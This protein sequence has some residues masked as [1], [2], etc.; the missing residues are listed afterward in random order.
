M[1]PPRPCYDGSSTMPQHPFYSSAVWRKARETHLRRHPYCE[2]CQNLGMRVRGSEVDHRIAI[3][4]GGHPTDPG[5]LRTMCKTHHS[6]KTIMLDG[7][8]KDCGKSL[9]TTGPDG[10]PVEIERPYHAPRKTTDPRRR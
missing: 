8:H 2:V 4:A 7:Q 10:W 5:N 9:V 6:Q 3:N 1:I